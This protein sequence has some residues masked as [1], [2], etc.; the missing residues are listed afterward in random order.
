[1]V[2]KLK[3]RPSLA[4]PQ[5]QLIHRRHLLD[6]RSV[7]G[8]QMISNQVRLRDGNTYFGIL[9]QLKEYLAIKTLALM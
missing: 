6:S 3:L 9:V 5:R 1:M 8:S 7:A 4:V 2:R